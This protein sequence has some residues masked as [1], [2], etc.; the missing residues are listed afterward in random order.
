MTSRTVKRYADAAR[1]EDLF[2]GQ[3]Q[4][5]TSMLDDYKTYLEDRWND[6]CTNVWKL[7]EEKIIPLGCKGSYQIV[8][9]Y[10]FRKRTSP[11]PVTAGPPSTRA[12]AGWILHRPETLAEPEQLQLKNVR[13]PDVRP[14]GLCP[15]AQTSPARAMTRA[16]RSEAEQHRYGWSTRGDQRRQRS[17]KVAG[18]K[19]V[20]TVITGDFLRVPPLQTADVLHGELVV[21]QRP[22][23]VEPRSVHE[24]VV[25]DD[26]VVARCVPRCHHFLV[27]HVR[28]IGPDSEAHLFP[29]FA[30]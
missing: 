10:L 21:G 23:R 11:R 15:P 30:T 22:A 1:P 14:R 4:N 16:V 8:R 28:G 25:V 20:R 7:W 3:W 13:A 9:A 12:V 29:Q 24:E 6:G 27:P 19:Q 17:R 2:A 5:R 18:G 26:A